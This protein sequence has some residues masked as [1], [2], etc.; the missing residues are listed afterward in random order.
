MIFACQ[1]G[2]VSMPVHLVSQMQTIQNLLIDLGGDEIPTDPIPVHA[3]TASTMQQVIA[4]CT[5]HDGDLC[6]ERQMELARMQWDDT[7][8]LEK[9][10]RVARDMGASSATALQ[11]AQL[12]LRLHTMTSEQVKEACDPLIIHHEWDRAFVEALRKDMEAVRLL[13]LAANYLHVEH[14]LSLMSM[15]VAMELRG[16]S[17]QELRAFLQVE[18]DFTHEEDEENMRLYKESLRYE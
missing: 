1:D 5:A 3:I 16:K 11:I 15:V 18:N 4:Y 8:E 6:F 7:A 10:L 9:S 2:E 14:L 17:P 12:G 13:I